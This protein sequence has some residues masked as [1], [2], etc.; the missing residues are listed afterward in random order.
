VPLI[1]LDLDDTVADRDTAFGHWLSSV[2]PG[3]AADEEGAR[4]FLV[5]QDAGG[6]RPRIE[7]LAAARERF[8]L[9]SSVDEL[10][11]DYRRL[12]LAG[13]LPLADEVRRYLEM[14]RGEGWKVAVVTNGESGVQEATV[15]RIG[16]APLLDACVVSGTVGIR[17]PDPRIFALAA[18][19]CG[20]QLDGAWMVG[21]GQVDVLGAAHAAI[22]SVW[23]TR[24]RVWDRTDVCPAFVAD[25]LMQALSLVRAGGPMP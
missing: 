16:L 4:R 22:T 24:G 9:V 21:D 3:W 12:T 15:E 11:A 23:L 13:F 10:L 25:S 7:F 14:M 17:K 19:R 18:E 5:E 20:E 6:A 2:L 8:G 1:F